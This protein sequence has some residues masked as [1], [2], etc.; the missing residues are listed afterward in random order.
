VQP[1]ESIGALLQR[2]AQDINATSG[3]EYT[4]TVPVG[5]NSLQILRS[6]GSEIDDLSVRENDPGIQSTM[7][8]VNRPRLAARIHFIEE[9]PSL[10][11][12]AI[13]VTLNDRVATVNTAW[14]RTASKVTEALVQAIRNA[15]FLVEVQPPEIVV[16]WD[17]VNS[18]TLTRVGLRST[19]PAIVT[20][21]V[22]LDP[23]PAEG[24]AAGVAGVTAL[25]LLL[26]GAG[27]WSSRRG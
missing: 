23:L 21:D 3:D 14:N 4:A 6:D 25:A 8:T 27:A 26:C 18:S 1:G 2:L 13:V 19:D 11:G 7:V 5:S 12:G 20:S 15:G 16:L 9:D 17:T 22:G 10:A 24:S